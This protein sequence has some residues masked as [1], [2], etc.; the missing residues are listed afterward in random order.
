MSCSKT[1]ESESLNYEGNKKSL[2]KEQT[3]LWDKLFSATIL[4]LCNRSV[5]ISIWRNAQDAKNFYFPNW[6]EFYTNNIPPR[7]ARLSSLSNSRDRS[8]VEIRSQSNQIEAVF[9]VLRLS[10]HATCTLVT[11]DRRR[12]NLKTLNCQQTNPQLKRQP[13]SPNTLISS[14]TRSREYNFHTQQQP[15]L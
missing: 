10:L 1:A 5:D 12:F 2:L 6:A 7:F 8:I 13:P 4:L 9:F 15:P 3:F 11:T 14:K